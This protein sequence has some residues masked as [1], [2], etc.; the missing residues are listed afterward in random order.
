[1]Q[2]DRLSKAKFLLDFL[3]LPRLRPATRKIYRGGGR[4]GGGGQA[5]KNKPLTG[6]ESWFMGVG[7]KGAK[8][9]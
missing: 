9:K 4:M 2:K 7:S 1:M 3:A 8:N 5:S 6:A